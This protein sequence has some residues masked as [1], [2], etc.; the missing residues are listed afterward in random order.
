MT[1]GPAWRL[2]GVGPLFHSWCSCFQLPQL[3]QF[4]K[5]GSWTVFTILKWRKCGVVLNPDDLSLSLFDR[6]IFSEFETV[7]DLQ[8]IFPGHA[9]SEVVI[10]DQM[11]PFTMAISCPRIITSVLLDTFVVRTILVPALMCLGQPWASGSF[12]EQLPPP[13]G[14]LFWWFYHGS[15]PYALWFGLLISWVLGKCHI[16]YHLSTRSNPRGAI[17][18]WKLPEIGRILSGDH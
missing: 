17:P 12:S 13:P 16:I 6:I 18:C 10:P 3:Q 8:V 9:E 4:W 7:A 15:K 14:D 2:V 11:H 5:L 1:V